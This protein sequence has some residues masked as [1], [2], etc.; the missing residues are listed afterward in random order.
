MFR[1]S[2]LLPRLPKRLDLV[3]TAGD[4]DAAQVGVAVALH[5]ADVQRLERRHVVV[6]F[7][8]RM[9][10]LR[11]PVL[12]AV[13]ENDRLGEVGVVRDDVG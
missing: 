4:E 12:V 5:E 2:V 6:V 1:M 10:G 13:E 9:P 11:V 8:I 7:R 3:G